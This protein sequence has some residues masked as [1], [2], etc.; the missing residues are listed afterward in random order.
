MTLAERVYTRGLHDLRTRATR[1]RS[2]TLFGGIAGALW[3]RIDVHR[4]LAYA[5]AFLCVFVCVCACVCTCALMRRNGTDAITRP[6][7]RGRMSLSNLAVVVSSRLRNY[8]VMFGRPENRWI[9]LYEIIF[10]WAY[11]AI[12]RIRFAKQSR[13]TYACAR[14]IW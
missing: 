10:T 13:A 6:K 5:V 11:A 12:E 9:I 2:P 3:W 4:E 1:Y 7:W 8:R 14:N